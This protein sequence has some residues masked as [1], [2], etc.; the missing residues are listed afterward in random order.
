MVVGGGGGS[1]ASLSQQ[2]LPLI[3]LPSLPPP[4]PLSVPLSSPSFSR[5]RAS[6][7]KSRVS[8]LGGGARL[9]VVGGYNDGTILRTVD[10]FGQSRRLFVSARHLHAHT[11]THAR[12]SGSPSIAVAATCVSVG[13]V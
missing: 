6:A 5:L 10:Y 13:R 2:S 12:I 3:P 11:H 8:R 9:Y 1:Q 7:D 4:P